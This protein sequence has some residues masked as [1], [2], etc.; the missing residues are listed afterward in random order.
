[1]PAVALTDIGNMMGAYQFI[2]E[3]FRHNKKIEDQIANLRNDASIENRDDKIIE[4][5]QK[6]ILTYYWK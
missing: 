3:G 4:L 1:M 5:D 2:E 6:K